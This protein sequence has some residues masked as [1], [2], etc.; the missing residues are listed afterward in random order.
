[1]KRRAILIIAVCM[2]G[3]G[4]YLALS[5]YRNGG[6]WTSSNTSI[7]GFCLTMVGAGIVG[8]LSGEISREK[9]VG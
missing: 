3:L 7:M 2:W 4:L 8:L 5:P 6:D 9:K 1:M